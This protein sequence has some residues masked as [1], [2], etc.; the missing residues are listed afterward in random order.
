MVILSS[1]RVTFSVPYKNV[2]VFEDEDTQCKMLGLKMR[3]AVAIALACIA[4]KP[5]LAAQ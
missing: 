4:A 3:P 5:F 2:S 1:S